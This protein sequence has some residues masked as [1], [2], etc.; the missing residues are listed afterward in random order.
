MVEKP[1]KINRRNMLKKA[2]AATGF[3]VLG[4]GSS[5]LA[6]GALNKMGVGDKV[7]FKVTGMTPLS[8][9]D[10]QRTLDDANTSSYFQDLQDKIETRYPG[11]L[12]RN[13]SNITAN[14]IETDS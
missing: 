12:F 4:L 14:R 1:V 6:S 7:D 5:G 11:S 8:D 2:T 3:G 9:G 13:Y 10:A